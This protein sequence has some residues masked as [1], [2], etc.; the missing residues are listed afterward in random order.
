LSYR[1]DRLARATKANDLGFR[2]LLNTEMVFVAGGK[3]PRSSPLANAT[4]ADF[5]I[6]EN[7]VTVS[8]WREIFANATITGYSFSSNNSSAFGGNSTDLPAV[9]LNWY[10]AI[11][12]CNAYSESEG[13]KPVYRHNNAIYKTGNSTNPVVDPTADGYRLPTEAEWEWAARG[14]I[15]STNTTFSGSNNST[16]V[17]WTRENSGNSTKQVGQ[18]LPNTLG[19][20][21]MS[22]NA[23]EWC[24]D[25]VSPGSL[26]TR[27]K[28]GS[29][30]GTNATATVS[31]QYALT[32]N[33]ALSNTGL[34]VARRN[35]LDF[36]FFEDIQP[37]LLGQLYEGYTIGAIGGGGSYSWTIVNGTLPPGML[38]VPSSSFATIIGTP[39]RE[40][41]IYPAKFLFTLRLTSGIESKLI[42]IVFE[43]NSPPSTP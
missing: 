19:L 3:L 42:D 8:K 2:I 40:N 20:H 5:Q 15:F 32:A 31:Y 38:L 10:D 18:K 34:R 27:L 4:V 16:H 36:V 22:G 30:L 23:L 7:E 28:G 14:G 21:D 24:W 13:L 17:A 33:S 35:V 39:A 43:V 11:K 9:N 29:F 25:R 12:W 26:Q 1:G 6:S 37:A 41:K